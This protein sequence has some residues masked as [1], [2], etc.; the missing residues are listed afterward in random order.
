MKTLN[1]DQKLQLLRFICSFAWAD[2]EVS[3]EEKNFIAMAVLA[4]DL[5][6]DDARLVEGWLSL[7]PRPEDIDPQDVPHEHRRLFLDHARALIQADGVVNVRET[8]H[9]RLFRDL[10]R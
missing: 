9:Y 10:T 2:L 6:P 3:P 5:D 1:N 4:F 7:P 8:T